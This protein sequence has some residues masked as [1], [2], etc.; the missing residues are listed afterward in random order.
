MQGPRT[1]ALLW[2]LSL[3]AV[4]VLWTSVSACPEQ[5]SH[6]GDGSHDDTRRCNES[7]QH[8]EGTPQPE[9]HHLEDRKPLAVRVKHPGGAGNSAVHP[10]SP[11]LHW[12]ELVPRTG[13]SRRQKRQWNIPLISLSENSLGPFPE[14]LV[15][16]ESDKSVTYDLRYSITGSGADQDPVGLFIIDS[17]TGELKVMRSIDREEYQMFRLKG[18]AISTSGLQVEE[19]CDLKITI[20]DQND[21]PPVFNTS[22]QGAVKEGSLPGTVVMQLIATDRDDPKTANARLFYKILS[23]TPSGK[24][25]AVNEKTGIVTT[26]SSGLDRETT[27]SYS[28]SVMATDSIGAGHGLSSMASYTVRLI[29]I[30]DNAP[31][32]SSKSFSG[33]VVENMVGATVA[34]IACSDRDEEFSANWRAVY[35]IVSGNSGGWFAV[36]TDPKTNQGIITTVKALDYESMQKAQLGVS[37]QNEVPLLTS[38]GQ[39][40]SGYKYDSSTVSVTVLN[41]A[42][43]PVFMPPER[44]VSIAEGVAIATLLTTFTAQDGDRDPNARIR[45]QKIMDPANWLRIDPVTGAVYTTAV[46]DRESSYVHNNTYT[47]TILAIKDGSPSMTSTGTLVLTVQDINDHAPVLLNG[48]VTSC[49]SDDPTRANI[50]AIDRDNYP[51]AGPMRFEVVGNEAQALWAIQPIDDRSAYI[52]YRNGKAPGT[53]HEVPVRIQD[54]QGKA[55]EHMVRVGICEC[56]DNSDVCQAW[57]FLPPAALVGGAGLSPGAIA[58]LVLSLLLLPLL[59]LLLMLLF[60]KCCPMGVAGAGGAGK[61]KLFLVPADDGIKGSLMSYHDEGA[62]E[63]DKNMALSSLH[64]AHAHKNGGSVASD[65]TFSRLNQM[66]DGSAV[67]GMAA[68]AAAAAAA[69]GAAMGAGMAGASGSSEMRN[70]VTKTV[71]TTQSSSGAHNAS[72]HAAGAVGAAGAAGAVEATGAALMAGAAGMGQGRSAGGDVHSG[73]ATTRSHG[74]STGGRY[75][76][77]A[78]GFDGTEVYGADYGLSDHGTW[79]HPGRLRR[80]EAPPVVTESTSSYHYRSLQS[81]RE[82]VKNVELFLGEAKSLAD[83]DPSAPPYETL[84]IY[85]YE[86]N[87]TPTDSL[88]VCS[89]IVDEEART[90]RLIS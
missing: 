51:N 86:G 69:G 78:A 49:T 46:L 45:Y 56:F 33:T 47:A 34:T 13:S 41:Q 60:S 2:M 76:A 71:T 66:V 21:N 70:E 73:Y 63:V 18:H 7:V 8:G 16:I 53:I 89:V 85:D 90:S 37:V 29:D 3:L 80:V 19:P 57:P 35:T 5:G 65:A 62:G 43:G 28:L 68:G 38:T 36:R 17:N 79:A 74:Y 67:G 10:R 11:V 84:L 15:S 50:T 22:F 75:G 4:Q 52:V 55:S 77:G 59:A 24:M 81:H 61:G 23:Q 87:A 27:S 48:N 20:I 25:F 88:S 44:Q 31:V 82:G 58:A 14:F 83:R 42:E 12:D 26:L 72:G 64:G 32:F 6:N 1:G 9:V 30:N 54:R 39:V 40:I